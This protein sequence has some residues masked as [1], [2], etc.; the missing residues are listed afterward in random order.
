MW[1]YSWRSWLALCWLL[2]E[3]Q[4]FLFHNI[5]NAKSMEKDGA[6]KWA[7]LVGDGWAT[8]DKYHANFAGQAGVKVCVLM[9]VDVFRLASV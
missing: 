8:L 5:D 7:E 9:Y 3:L 2:T 1:Y 4:A 6:T